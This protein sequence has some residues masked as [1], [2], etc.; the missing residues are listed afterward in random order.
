MSRIKIGLKGP[1][2]SGFMCRTGNSLSFTRFANSSRI[3]KVFY[4]FSDKSDN[5]S[6]SLR[7]GGGIREGRSASGSKH[8]LRQPG[9]RASSVSFLIRL[10]FGSQPVV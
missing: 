5:W 4:S 10:S 1:T 8:R 3:S 2:G 7:V 6:G 9:R